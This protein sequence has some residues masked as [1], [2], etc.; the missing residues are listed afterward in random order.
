MARGQQAKR[1]SSPPA[2]KCQK[3]PSEVTQT[4]EEA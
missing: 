2:F 4:L 3:K 1:Q